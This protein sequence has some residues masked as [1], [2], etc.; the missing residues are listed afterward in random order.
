MRSPPRTFV[1]GFREFG[2]FAVNPS[3]PL[4][5]SCGR[6]F[7]VLEV[8]YA[9][10][11][12]FLDRLA[13]ASAFDQLLMLGL[14]GRGTRIEVERFARNWI[15]D[16]PD[17]RGSVRGPAPIY[18]D[19]PDALPSTLFTSESAVASLNP[20]E[21]AGFYLC[22]YI[23]YRALRLRPDIRI[24]FVHVPPTEVMPLDAQRRDLTR[25]LVAIETPIAPA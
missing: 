24:G 13:D 17:V 2:G 14:R 15:G 18:H 7:E 8:S 3:A 21:D 9:A 23:Y 19:A 25:L 1:T 11:D 6:P 16:L 10:A 20:S 4:A 22:N 5:E 12:D